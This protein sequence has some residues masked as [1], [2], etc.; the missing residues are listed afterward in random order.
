MDVSELLR[1]HEGKTLEFKRDLSSPG[2][3]VRTVVAFANTAGGD[4]V[5]GV[6]DGTRDVV[7][8]EDALADEERLANLIADRIAP[9][10][11]PDIEIVAWRSTNVLVA[12]IADSPIRPHYVKTQG[13]QRGVYVR[14]GS[15][16]RRAGPE[17]IQEMTRYVQGQSFDEEPFPEANS[18]DID[19]RAASESFAD[20]RRLRRQDLQTL[21]ILTNYQGGLVPT[22]GGL[23][24]FGK[25]RLS[26]FP[27]AWIRVGLFG[28]S[29]RTRILDSKDI[30][31]HLPPAV[32]ETL[33]QVQRMTPTSL[34]IDGARHTPLSSYPLSAVR[35]AIVNAAV[36]AD[37][38]QRGATISVSVFS[39]RI[40][41]E[42]PGL[43]PFGLTLE[44]IQ[45]G[46][47][48]LR[49]RVI[50]RVFKELRLIEQWG[51]GIQ[52]MT[53]ACREAG[54]ADPLFEERATSFRVTMR[55]TRIGEARVDRSDSE[56]LEVLRAIS[57][58]DGLSTSEIAERIGRSDRAARTRLLKLTERGLVLRIGS[59]RNDPTARW[60]IARPDSG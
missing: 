16:S 20:L 53:S 45:E 14:V 29:D 60:F 7:G 37:Y 51:S 18:E 28:G 49:N 54:M 13:P 36:H 57:G 47:S 40:E 41:I 43:L 11:L 8:V 27:D 31:S 32:E 35:E 26:F 48:K 5:V 46:T 22:T 33:A 6:D 50:G 34:E 1:R 21:R 59:S 55:S 17:L 56:I 38:A 23:I 44:D 24:L 10:V 52:R 12:R 4:L 3:I 30:T 58:Q 19:F 25:D 42:N 9:T 15:T 2:P 39:D